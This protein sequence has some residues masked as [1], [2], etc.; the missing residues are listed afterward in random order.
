MFESKAADSTIQQTFVKTA[1]K[2]RECY[3]LFHTR[4]DEVITKLGHKKGVVLF[5]PKH[6]Q[7]NSEDSSVAHSF[8][9]LDREHRVTPSQESPNNQQSSANFTPPIDLGSPTQGNWHSG[10][11]SSKVSFRHYSKDCGESQ[12]INYGSHPNGKFLTHTQAQARILKLTSKPPDM[13]TPKTLSQPE[14]HIPHIGPEEKDDEKDEEKEP[15]TENV[16]EEHHG[17]VNLEGKS[18]RALECYKVYL[19]CCKVCKEAQCKFRCTYCHYITTE[20]KEIKEELQPTCKLQRAPQ[21][22]RARDVS[23]SNTQST[24]SNLLHG[25]S[26]LQ[27]PTPRSDEEDL[28]SHQD[29]PS[30]VTAVEHPATLSQEGSESQQSLANSTSFIDLGFP[31]QCNCCSRKITISIPIPTSGN[32]LD[33]QS[34][35]YKVSGKSKGSRDDQHHQNSQ[36]KK[37][38]KFKLGPR[39]DLP[40][41]EKSKLVPREDLPKFSSMN[42]K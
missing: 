36:P 6:L 25:I 31:R 8:P 22:S 33:D 1:A 14:S 5:R 16:S 32:S 27:P 19:E 18:L 41:Q 2:H 23:Q 29:Q 10:K 40:K 9:N 38:E 37:Q 12:V 34:T 11:T 39:D 30:Q 17:D 21:L 24:N 7:N 42:H 26:D 20:A 13:S 15:K 28:T 35:H 3:I 4:T